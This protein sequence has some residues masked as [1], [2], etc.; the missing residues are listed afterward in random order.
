MAAPADKNIVI[1]PD[2]LQSIWPILLALL[3]LLATSMLSVL[4]SY[5]RHAIEVHNLLR[6]S[7]RRRQAYLAGLRKQD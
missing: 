2:I 4:A 1:A 3:Y 7:R 6:E 5:R